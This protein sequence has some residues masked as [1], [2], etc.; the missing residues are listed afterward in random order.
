[1]IEKGKPN[2]ECDHSKYE[3]NRPDLEITTNAVILDRSSDVEFIE[4]RLNAY[5]LKYEPESMDYEESGPMIHTYPAP[6]NSP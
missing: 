1:M 2:R 6:K 4:A 5:E 3:T